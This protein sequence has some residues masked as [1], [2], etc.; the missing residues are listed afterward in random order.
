MEIDELKKFLNEKYAQF[1]C[2]GFIETDPISIPHQFSRKEDIEIAAF[3]SATIAWGQRP[4][5]IRNANKFI[6]L[7]DGEPYKFL[8]RTAIEDPERFESFVHRTF[9]GVDCLYFMRALSSIYREHGG[10]E[11]LFSE[12]Y[13]IDGTVKSA[14][15]YFRE[16]FLSFDPQHRTEKHIANPAKGSSAK[17]I[18]MFL[19]WMVR[20]S[21]FGVDFGLWNSIP[22]SALMMPLDVH[23][24]SVARKLGLLQRSQNDWQAVEELT[25]N[26]RLFDSTDPV[27]YDFALFGLGA[28]EKF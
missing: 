8:T 20:S 19:R 27:K 18:N 2:T 23:S 4:T 28:F 11:K 12:G 13:S 1:S 3:V 6:R 10:L 5:I 17:R 7:M 14:I 26:L 24:G 16:R 9:N 25:A 15:I 21:N 22:V